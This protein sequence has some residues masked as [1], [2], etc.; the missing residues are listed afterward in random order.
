MEDEAG[1]R[2]RKK[3]ISHREK[4]ALIT[5]ILRVSDLNMNVAS[6]DWTRIAETSR[7]ERRQCQ[8]IW[9]QYKDEIR[10]IPDNELLRAELINGGRHVVYR[11]NS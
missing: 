11:T 6:G 4:L 3:N 5:K 7:I 9:R 2:E 1:V 10:R 8:N